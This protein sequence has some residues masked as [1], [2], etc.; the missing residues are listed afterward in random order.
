[1]DA[2]R[3]QSTEPASSCQRMPA[4]CLATRPR[5]GARMGAEKWPGSKAKEQTEEQT[6]EQEWASVPSGPTTRRLSP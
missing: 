3:G 1:M 6:E 5:L 2:E 4:H